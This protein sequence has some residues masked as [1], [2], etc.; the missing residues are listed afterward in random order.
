MTDNVSLL[1]PRLAKALLR[2][3][4]DCHVDV[5]LDGLITSTLQLFCLE[6]SDGRLLHSDEVYPGATSAWHKKLK[7]TLRQS[8]RAFGSNRQTRGSAGW[9]ETIRVR[10]YN[11]YEHR[12]RRNILG[13]CPCFLTSAR[14][15]NF[16]SSKTTSVSKH[17][18]EYQGLII[19]DIYHEAA[20]ARATLTWNLTDII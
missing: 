5:P 15:Q 13:P 4:A 14:S 20:Q 1:P 2:V 11:M 17:S 8:P 16:T 19:F 12:C 3:V 7:P 10:E 18:F 6:V 9:Y